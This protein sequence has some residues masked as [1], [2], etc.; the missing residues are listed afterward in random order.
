MP[1]NS[2]LTGP[3]WTTIFEH[4]NIILVENRY[5]DYW[6]AVN[7]IFIKNG[8]FLKKKIKREKD[9]ITV[10][11]KGKTKITKNKETNRQKR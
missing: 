3:L 9:K 4:K 10:N 8:R 2:F 5:H 7:K 6:E 11:N 1:Q